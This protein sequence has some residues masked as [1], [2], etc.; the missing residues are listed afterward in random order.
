[1]FFNMTL[2][3]FS[4]APLIFKKKPTVFVRQRCSIYLLK[5]EELSIFKEIYTAKYY[6]ASIASTKNTERYLEKMFGRRDLKMESSFTSLDGVEE[7]EVGSPLHN[8]KFS[9]LQKEKLWISFTL[10]SVFERK[11]SYPSK[12]SEITTEMTI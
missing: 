10:E 8:F 3:I 1:M 11:L 2:K 9:D 6:P 4:I 5:T 7:R 12:D